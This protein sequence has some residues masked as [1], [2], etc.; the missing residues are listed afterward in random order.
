[1]LLDP[2]TTEAKAEMEFGADTGKSMN[3]IRRRPSSNDFAWYIAGYVDG[4]GCFCV[5]I[6]PQP[7]NRVGWEVRPSFS[8]SQNSDRSQVIDLLPEIFGCGFI[9]PDRSDKTLKYEVRSLHGLL[10]GVIPF[11]ERY[12]LQ[13]SKANDFSH[14]R[15]ICFLMR[16]G[17][18]LQVEG[19][20]GIAQLAH[21]MNPSGIRKYS[22]E[23]MMR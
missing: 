19:L 9:R 2:V 18:H 22:L 20:V 16:E 3:S 1:M 10:A 21:Q 23:A 12:P 13:S 7:R 15:S 5:S 8:V 4:E 17:R 14:L 6:R 11:F